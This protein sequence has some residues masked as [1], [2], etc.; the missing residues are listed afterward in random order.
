MQSGSSVR[1]LLID[2]QAGIEQVF[3]D[4]RFI[5]ADGSDQATAPASFRSLF[6]LPQFGQDAVE[7]GKIGGYDGGIQFKGMTVLDQQRD[8]RGALGPMIWGI[9]QFAAV[10]AVRTDVEHGQS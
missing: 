3:H 7:S 4:L 9:F 1:N 6:L 5:E 2:R 10:P 8:D